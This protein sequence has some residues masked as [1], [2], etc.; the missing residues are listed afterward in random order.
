VAIRLSDTPAASKKIDVGSGT[1]AAEGR[2]SVALFALPTTTEKLPVSSSA[3]WL[4]EKSVSGMESVIMLGVEP[5]WF[6]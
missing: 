1:A 4:L 2:K 3:I 6:E 5:A